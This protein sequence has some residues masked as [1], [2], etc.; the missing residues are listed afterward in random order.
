MQ[1]GRRQRGRRQRGRRLPAR[2]SV[3]SERE[4]EREGGR[5]AMPLWEGEGEE[6]G[7]R[8][9]RHGDRRWRR[10]ASGEGLV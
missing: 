8:K 5:A 10:E 2:C 9:G 1:K 4:R 3:A 7:E 6:E